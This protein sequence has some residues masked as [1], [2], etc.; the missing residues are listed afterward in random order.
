VTPHG[1]AGRLDIMAWALEAAAVPFGE[2]RTD[3]TWLAIFRALDEAELPELLY[4]AITTIADMIRLGDAQEAA[5]QTAFSPR[6]ALDGL[7][8][9]L[10]R[11]LEL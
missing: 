8:L 1:R 3:L 4:A 11:E 6:R 9:L 2:D 5:D 10:D 7:R